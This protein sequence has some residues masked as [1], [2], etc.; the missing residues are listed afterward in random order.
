M[1]DRWRLRRFDRRLADVATWRLMQEVRQRG[2]LRDAPISEAGMTK[3]ENLRR[4]TEGIVVDSFGIPLLQQM[5][6]DGLPLGAPRGPHSGSSAEVQGPERGSVQGDDV[7][8][9][10]SPLD[11]KET[12]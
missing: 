12:T 8:A 9:G 1:F 3:G 7:Q 5:G 11:P 4:P 6:D 10:Q 2:T